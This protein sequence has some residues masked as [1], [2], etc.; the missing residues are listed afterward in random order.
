M[1]LLRLMLLPVLC[2]THLGCTD[3]PAG[4]AVS[5]DDAKP[6]LSRGGPRNGHPWV[7]YPDTLA[8]WVREMPEIAKGTPA[9]EV[10]KRLGEPDED[11]INAPEI[12]FPV[13]FPDRGYDRCVL[14]FVAMDRFDEYEPISSTNLREIESINL[15]F[16][17]DNRYKTYWV[18]NP[19]HPWKLNE[20]PAT[21]DQDLM[22]LIR[23]GPAASTD[24]T[25]GQISH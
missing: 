5:A 3:T 24:P 23:E 9:D 2:L 11:Y 22:S 14:Y 1:R 25:V 6:H 4:K 20:P 16:D 21:P 18:E 10:I 12:F 17:P 7:V 8:K 13:F 15:I 19:L